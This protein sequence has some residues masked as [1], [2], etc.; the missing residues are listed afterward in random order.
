[1]GRPGSVN[2]LHR[3]RTPLGVCLVAAASA[4]VALLAGCSNSNSAAGNSSGP[5]VDA[6]SLSS[7]GE[8]STAPTQ[9][10]PAGTTPDANGVG[11]GACSYLTVGQASSLAG[12][13]VKK[14]VEQSQ[15]FGPYTSN[16]CTYIFNPGNAV[17][18]SVGFVQLSDDPRGLFNQY[19]LTKQA[20]A[21]F[22]DV[23]GV[24][25][26]AFYANQ[27]LNILK[28]HTVVTIFVGRAN[29]TPRG[30][31]NIPDEK[32]AASIVLPQL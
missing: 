19:R 28:G 14:G 13:A 22:Q 4:L 25:D 10:T 7:Q 11:T 21:E 1:M 27:N 16:S 30:P 26:A 6:G 32:A 2:G 12:S 31:G 18:V 29:G 9:G 3:P 20:D 15:P 23:A 17:G 24:G 8:A 5:G